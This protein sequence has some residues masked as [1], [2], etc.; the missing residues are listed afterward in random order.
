M[1]NFALALVM[2]TI[3]GGALVS[4]AAAARVYRAGY[5]PAYFAPAHYDPVPYRGVI[6]APWYY[7]WPFYN[8]WQFRWRP[9][10]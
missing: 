2:A 8:D 5:P 1:K 7:G 6:S 4:P 9:R 10:Y 3:V